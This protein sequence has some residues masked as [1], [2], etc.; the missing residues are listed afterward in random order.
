MKNLSV[1]LVLMALWSG[2]HAERKASVVVTTYPLYEV[3]KQVGGDT[4]KLEKLLP[5]GTDVHMFRLSPDMV[6][7]ASRASMFIYNGAGLEPWAERMVANLPETTKAIDMSKEVTLYRYESIENACPH[8]HGH[9]HGHQEETSGELPIDPHYWLAPNN[10]IAMTEKA[11]KELSALQPEYAAEYQK[12]AEAF[13]RELDA[14]DALYKKQLTACELDTIVSNHA[15]FNYLAEAYGF[16]AV[17]VTGLSPEHRPSAKA[18]AQIMDLVNEKGIDRVFFEAYVSN[19][20]ARSLARE[21]GTSVASLQ[22]LANLSS[23]EAAS[24][25]NYITIMKENLEKIAKA[26]EC[27]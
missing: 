27:R 24:N 10:M 22:P 6:V 8:D 4:V 5:Y 23:D 11:A 26:L 1:L 21:T 15:A 25:A 7:K 18:M 3:L 9:D 2:L 19:D 12:N 14:L 17:S 13:I 16:K 20:V